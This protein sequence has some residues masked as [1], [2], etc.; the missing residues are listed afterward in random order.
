MAEVGVAE[1]GVAEVG[2]AEAGAKLEE[3]KMQCEI[4]VSVLVVSNLD[5]VF[6]S[7]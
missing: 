2:E 6:C 4:Y 5:C 1:V 3:G 7:D